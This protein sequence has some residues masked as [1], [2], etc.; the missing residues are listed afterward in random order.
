[1]TTPRY[2]Y[3]A[4]LLANGEVLIAGGYAD[5][6][7]SVYLAS[8]E[9]YN[10]ATGTFSATGSMTTE[11][12]SPT[13]TLLPNG[14]V[15]VAGGTNCGGCVLASA[16]LYD[17]VTG[18]FS[19]TGPMTTP[20]YDHTATLLFNGKVLVAGGCG[21]SGTCPLLGSAELY[22]PATKTFSV[23]GSLTTARYNHY[24]TLLPDGKVLIAGGAD[25]NGSQNALTGA[26]LYEPATGTF[27]TTGSMITGRASQGSAALLLTGKVLFPGGCGNSGPLAS[28]ELYNETTG[29]FSATGSMTTARCYHTAAL[30]PTGEVLIAGGTTGSSA[31]LYEPT[32]GA[33]TATGSMTTGGI[34]FVMPAATLLPDGEVLVAGGGAVGASGG[35]LASAQLYRDYS[36]LWRAAF[37]VIW[38]I[39]K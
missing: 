15:L 37:G 7:L 21:G 8:A 33:F 27:S 11:R 32:K 29:A 35:P 34:D 31:E 28:A 18:T 16:E 14:K 5:P 20:R 25:D 24:A 4:T 38:Q 3:S 36:L 17:P 19:A 23:T 6:S 26:E 1:M 10:P 9:L 22:D 39:G 13:A 2:Q 12:A 30:L